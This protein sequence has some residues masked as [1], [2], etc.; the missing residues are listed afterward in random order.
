[1]K[2]AS[3]PKPMPPRASTAPKERHARRC[4]RRE[5][6]LSGETGYAGRRKAKRD[7]KPAIFPRSC[8]ARE[9]KPQCQ[10]KQNAKRGARGERAEVAM[11]S[12][13]G[14]T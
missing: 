14:S 5:D 8:Q 4:A 9:A 2:V 6:G 13:G 12:V 10:L 11:P 3:T 7:G 1:M